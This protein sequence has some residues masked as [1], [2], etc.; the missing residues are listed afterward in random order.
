MASPLSVLQKASLFK[1]VPAEE[2]EKLAALARE[3]I[4]APA[5]ELFREGSAGDALYIV[6]LGTV[7]VSKKATSG[8][9]EDVATLGSG[10]YFGEMALVDDD[11]QR[12]ATVFAKEPTTV[13]VYDRASIEKLCQADDTFA[14]YLYRSVAR[15]LARR[16]AVT[17]NDAAYYRAQARNT[18]S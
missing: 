8:S 16:L 3:E 14:K 18:K 1:G 6:V 13:H 17:T 4:V 9:H 2:L 15:G 12:S 7:Q 11:H 5:Q 10:S